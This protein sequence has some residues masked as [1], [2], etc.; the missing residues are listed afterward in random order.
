MKRINFLLF[1]LCMLLVADWGCEDLNSECGDQV[2][3]EHDAYGSFFKNPSDIYWGVTGGVRSYTYNYQFENICTKQNPKVSFTLGLASS[4][5]GSSNPIS[6]SAGVYTCLGVQAQHVTMLPDNQQIFYRGGPAEIGMQQC[7]GSQA[8][9]T[10]YPYMTISFNTLGS[11][12]D[13]SL[14][15]VDKVVMMIAYIEKREPK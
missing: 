10:I 12:R 15:M 11:D 13:D 7:F 1:A 6:V 9:A 5:A 14:Y 8:S 2:K 3:D 4:N